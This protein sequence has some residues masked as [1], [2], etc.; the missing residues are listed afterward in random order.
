M[1]IQQPFWHGREYWKNISRVL[2]I[3]NGLFVHL[4]DRQGDFEQYRASFTAAMAMLEAS[5]LNI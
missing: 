1:T 4:N 5:I 2:E 3:K